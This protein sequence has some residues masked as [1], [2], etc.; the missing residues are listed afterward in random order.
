[1][2]E[3]ILALDLGTESFKLLTAEEQAGSWVITH[4]GSKEIPP[5]A[6]AAVRQQALKELIGEIQLKQFRTVVSVL[7]DSF[8]SV[9]QIYTPPIP[10]SELLSAIRWEMQNFLA[11]SPEETAV[12]LISLGTVDLGG[13]TKQRHIAAAVS[14]EAV[15]NHCA[16][17]ALAGIRPSQLIPKN[18]ALALCAEKLQPSSADLPRVVLEIGSASAECVVQEGLWPV[19]ARRIP[20]GSHGLTRE[21]SGMIVSGQGQV[22]LTADEA[23]QLKR[24]VGIPSTDAGDLGVKGIS[25]MQLFS[26]MRAWLDR[27]AVETERSVTFYGETSGRNAVS[28]IILLGGGAHLRGL[29]EWLSERLGVR[30]TVPAGLLGDQAVFG[31]FPSVRGGECAYAAVL[32]AVYGEGKGLNFLPAEIRDKTK[33]TIQRM[34]LAALG[35]G[36]A[37]ALVVSGVGLRLYQRNLRGQVAALEIEAASTSQRWSDLKEYLSARNRVMSEPRWRDFLMELSQTTPNQITLSSLSVDETRQVT[38]HGVIHAGPRAVQD[39]MADY[40][41]ALRGRSLTQVEL[42]RTHRTDNDSGEAEF[43][44]GGRLLP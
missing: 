7:D 19:F 37:A 20:G 1:M 9:R 41:S 33:R 30:V 40:L 16:L 21:M 31:K 6:G 24:R 42:R 14:V 12:D 18:W 5:D 3:K 32:G 35:A 15:R 10:A 17:L 23:E 11:I 29:P 34:F 2:A 26:L 36:L 8:S 44:I 13:V 39:L 4:L 25:G 43:E 22:A 27:L 38:L 28:E